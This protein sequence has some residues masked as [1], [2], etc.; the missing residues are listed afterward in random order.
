[1]QI[2]ATHHVLIRLSNTGQRIRLAID[3]RLRTHQPP[4]RNPLF[5][6]QRV[7]NA[8]SSLPRRQEARH[9]LRRP[10]SQDLGSHR[11]T[12]LLRR[13]LV[14]VS[15]QHSHPNQ[16]HRIRS[17]KRDQRAAEWRRKQSHS[18]GNGWPGCWGGKAVSPRGHTDGP[19]ALGLGLC[20]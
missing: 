15:R 18:R 2:C 8:H 3:P 17:P 19:P 4:P 9:L 13:V 10:H 5:C 20:V 7:Y 14:Y 16:Q 6:A 12:P 1:M 11:V